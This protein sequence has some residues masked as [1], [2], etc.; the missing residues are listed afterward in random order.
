TIDVGSSSLRTN[1]FTSDAH[2][3]TDYEAQHKYELHVT[4]DGGSEIDPETLLESLFSAIDETLRRA[5]SR[6]DHIQGVAMCSLVSNV[7]GIDAQGK[8]TTPIYTWADTR[9]AP[10]VARLRA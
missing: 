3:L 1:L 2:Q 7:M 9:C 6:A 5:G 4:P 8:P 10:D